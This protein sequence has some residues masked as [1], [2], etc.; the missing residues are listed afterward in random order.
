MKTSA[1][2]YF[3]GNSEYGTEP[4]KRICDAIPRSSDNL[5]SSPRYG[6][7]PTISIS[8]SGA[9]FSIIWGSARIKNWKPLRGISLPIVSTRTFSGHAWRWTGSK[10]PK[11]KPSGIT[12]IF[13]SV[14]VSRA[15]SRKP[16][17]HATTVDALPQID[18]II[19][20]RSKYNHR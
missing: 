18:R 16:S 6:P 13:T 1:S 7:S 9:A 2:R 15:S 14:S 17:L 20:F 8:K 12:S 3:C 19:G 10:R 5:R 11:S 4:A